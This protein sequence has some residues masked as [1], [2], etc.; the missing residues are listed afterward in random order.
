[1]TH[2]STIPSLLEC[3]DT[4]S[5]THSCGEQC[6]CEET[7]A[8]FVTVLD[9]IQKWYDQFLTDWKT[10]LSYTLSQLKLQLAISFPDIT[11]ANCLTHFWA[12]WLLCITSIRQLRAQ[13]LNLIDKRLFI[14]HVAPES[15][16]IDEL[17][18]CYVSRIL[19]SVDY[20]LQ[21]EVKLYGV[22][23]MSIPLHT[24][25]NVVE[26]GPTRFE[27][28]VHNLLEETRSKI[29]ARG[30]QDILIPKPREALV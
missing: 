8:G 7:L 25:Y 27:T 29:R 13:H 20:F 5:S 26:A 6:Q 1:M 24:A 28:P 17:I 19:Q 21:D 3:M 10:S 14:N 4:I 9:S 12:L 15:N 2:G 22:A 16:E 23:S 30:Y 11:V 18:V